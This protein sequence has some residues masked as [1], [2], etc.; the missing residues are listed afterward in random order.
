MVKQKEYKTV[1]FTVPAHKTFKIEAED[2]KKMEQSGL[3]PYDVFELY[4]TEETEEGE[5]LSNEDEA[6]YNKIVKEGEWGYGDPNISYADE[7]EFVRD[8]VF[9]WQGEE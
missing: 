2:V 4:W 8:E 5:P 7:R 1:Y 6:L 3:S 9:K